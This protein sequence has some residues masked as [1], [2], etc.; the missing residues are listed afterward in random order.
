VED[1]YG[2]LEVPPD[3]S[4]KTIKAQYRFLL[5]AWHPDKFSNAV[6][7]T[8]AEEK[9]KEINE[10][11]EVLSDPLRRAQYDRERLAQSSRFSTD[12]G[13][14]WKR[15]EAEAGQ[16][17]AEEER[18]RR[19]QAEAEQRRAEEEQQRRAQ[20]EAEQRRVEEEQQRRAQAEAEQRRA[21]EE[22]QRRAQAEAE[23]RRAEEEW[24]RRAQAEAEQR[25]AAEEERQQ[26]EQAE[27]ELRCAEEE[28]QRRREAET[29][30]QRT[31]LTCISVI[32]LLLV[33]VPLLVGLLCAFS[34]LASRLSRSSVNQNECY[35][36]VSGTK[37]SMTV[38]GDQ[39]RERCRE[40]VNQ[41][42][43]MPLPLGVH[44]VWRFVELDRKPTETIYCQ[45]Q[46]SGLLYEVRDEQTLSTIIGPQLC[47][48]LGYQNPVPK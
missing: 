21:E 23:Q 25:R 16:R 10:A 35:L 28:W 31:T 1:Y 20:A 39:A 8:R 2:I 32:F 47:K 33:G 5:H 24:Q 3:A 9:T 29:Q 15:E 4:Q 37:A 42:I 27:V 40:L 36:G 12:E 26:R 14:R 30:S 18:Q 41:R 34:A 7:K 46:I 22:W 11:Y 44:V 38:T 43:I 13:T 19:A 48:S 6:H 17:R 45:V